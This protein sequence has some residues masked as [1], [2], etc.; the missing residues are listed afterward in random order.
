[1]TVLREMFTGTLWMVA[2]RWSVRGIG[3]IST[4]VLARLLTPVDFGVIAMAMMT[5]GVIEVFSD[6]GMAFFIIRHP[7]PQRTH[8]DTVWT[9][10]LLLGI[11][12][13][14]ILYFL[15]HPAAEFF[16]EPKIGPVVQWLALRP[17]VGGV[18]NPGVIW[19]RKNLDFHRDFQFF[20]GNKV[21]AF[22]VTV[23]LAFMLRNYWA[24]VFGILAGGVAS[25]VQ[26]FSMHKYRPR[27]NI[28]ETRAV[29]GYSFWVLVQNLVG[30]LN[31]KADELVVGRLKS[32]VDMGL[33]NVMLDIGQSPVMEI[34]TPMG[35]V[36]FSGLA[37]VSDDPAAML[38]AFLKTHEAATII[39]FAIG[40]GLALIA[41]DFSSLLLGPQWA[42]HTLL[43]QIVA[44]SAVFQA[45]SAPFYTL[46]MVIGR[47]RDAAVLS[48]ARLAL[49]IAMTT[50]AGIWYDLNVIA[51]ARFVALLVTFVFAVT[52]VER[53]AAIPVQP[54][55]NSLLRATI[56]AGVMAAV[57]LLANLV[58]PP[59]P[60]LRLLLDIALGAFAYLGTLAVQWLI[61]GRPASV[62]GDVL[63]WAAQQL[64]SR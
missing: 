34:I 25:T 21:V 35:R 30:F 45:I 24:L 14:V 8:F 53:A 64:G 27:F 10:Q 20:V 63:N 13:A 5:V 32:T 28:S 26:S 61:A 1:M 48:G 7:D 46:L 31:Q 2:A 36:T 62:E 3:L 58:I 47:A 43:M 42:G 40:P 39:S 4:L 55:M 15:A 60:A 56:A 54:L 33:Y 38:S 49:L 12:L 6:T 23:G 16:H 29:W 41:S 19:F 44:V 11:F 57:I 51:A 18:Q 9:L 37:K 50:T 17:L 59:I 22:F 52:A